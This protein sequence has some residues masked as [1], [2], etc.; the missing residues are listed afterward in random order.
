VF[1]PPF[2]KKVYETG[3]KLGKTIEQTSSFVCLEPWEGGDDDRVFFLTK[4]TKKRR[5]GSF[6]PK[7]KNSFRGQVLWKKVASCFFFLKP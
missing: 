5:G 1:I 4:G 6:L 7:K 2:E 3:K